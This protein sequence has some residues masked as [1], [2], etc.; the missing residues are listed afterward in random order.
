MIPTKEN[1]TFENPAGTDGFEFLEFIADTPNEL[2]KLFTDM[3]FVKTGQH[4]SQPVELWQQGDINFVINSNPNGFAKQFYQ[5]HGPSVPGMAFRVKDLEVA[6]QHCLS[7]GAKPYAGMDSDW[8]DDQVRIIHGIGG[9]LLYLVDKYADDNIYNS[10]FDMDADA[11]AKAKSNAKLT[12]VDHV[13]HNV[14]KGDMDDWAQFYVDLFSFYQI[15][16]FDIHGKFTGLHSRALTSPCKKISI[17]INEPTD[18]QSQI[19]EYLDIYK[20]EGIQHIALGT[21]DIYQSVE[22]LQNIGM[23]FLDTPIT[24]Y[25]MIDERL[26][27]HGEPLDRMKK[28]R[29]LIDGS[30]KNGVETLL[31][32]FTETVIG[33]VFFEIIQ[34][35]GDEG[36]GEGNFQA[37][38]DSMELDQIE[39]GVVT[40]THEEQES[41]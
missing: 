11:V 37:L 29:V 34:R 19:Q 3:G 21:D 35:K 13:T 7:K 5:Q 25:R 38:F 40:P 30:T 23:K 33:P 12:Y 18:Q 17:P 14:F 28:D 6:Y 24:Y 39:R 26:P 41:T 1:T 32:I 8:T 10:L 16:Y 36:F 27:G 4:K 20:G 22:D 15:R 2:H 31:Q 9:N